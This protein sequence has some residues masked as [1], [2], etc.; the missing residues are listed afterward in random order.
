MRSKE[1]AD[2]AGVTVRTLRHYHQLGLLPEPP[3]SANG[4]RAY[5][6]VDLARVLRIKRL[7][8]LGIPLQ[9]VAEMLAEDQVFTGAESACEAQVRTKDETLADLDRELAAQIER[10][11]QQRRVI[12]E[13]R[14]RAIDPD[15]PPVFGEHL[16]RLRGAG[17]SSGLVDYERSG[18]LLV[19]RFF[20]ESSEET[21]AVSQFFE[22]VG[23]AGSVE[24]YVEFNERML[25]LSSDASEEDC[26]RLA[27]DFVSFMVPILKLG[28][29]K[30]GWDLSAEKIERLSCSPDFPYPSRNPEM[31][32]VEGKRSESESISP[33][34]YAAAD[35]L[36]APEE[37]QALDLLLDL[38]DEETLNDAQCRMND[39]VVRGILSELAKG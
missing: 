12:A 6:A 9:Q 27:E 33:K 29:E 3:R 36:P 13:L 10:L 32:C 28:C 2:F 5:G 24:A 19:D 26:R 14:E 17:A 25:N 20:D 39:L 21:E 8:S 22:L 18:L 23:E 1:L 16:A 34:T 7:A 31:A 4:Y 37:A 30:H 35:D 11:Q 15:V 38:Y